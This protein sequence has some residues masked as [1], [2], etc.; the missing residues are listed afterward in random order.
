MT[1]F[2]RLLKLQWKQTIDESCKL[3]NEAIAL[4]EKCEYAYEMLG[5]IEVQ[6]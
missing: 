5:T 3:I 6:R 4:D 1:L 2:C